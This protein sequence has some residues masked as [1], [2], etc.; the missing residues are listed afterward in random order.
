MGIAPGVV[1]LELGP[2]W[3]KSRS[4]LPFDKVPG[5]GRQASFQAAGSFIKRRRELALMK[6]DVS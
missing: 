6:A 2:V 3:I 4:K 5:G 1:P